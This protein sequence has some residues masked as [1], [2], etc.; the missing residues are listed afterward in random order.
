M[1]FA[2]GLAWTTRKEQELPFW[3]IAL[4]INISLESDTKY[5]TKQAFSFSG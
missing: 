5:T 1:S 2:M 4:D 3:F